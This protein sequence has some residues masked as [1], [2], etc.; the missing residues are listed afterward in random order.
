M[1]MNTSA[2]STDPLSVVLSDTDGTPTFAGGDTNNDGLLEQGETWSYTLT[3]TAPVAN[4]GDSHV[5]TATASGTDDEGN[6]ASAQ[7]TATVT[8]ANRNPAIQVVK[9]VSPGSVLEGTSGQNVTY[10]YVVT[11]TSAAST[12]PLSVVLSDSDGTPT[13]V[14]GDSNND[15]LLQQD[16]TWSYTLTVAAPVGNVGDSHVNTA[17]ATGTDDE[18][19]TA[20]AQDTATVTYTNVNP[21]IQVVKS[22]SPGSVLEGTS[23][24]NVTYSYVVTNTSAASTDPLSVVLSDS[25]GT[26]TF[27]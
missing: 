27:M 20:S 26:P 7:D 2:A 13:F 12:D 18:G 25:D 5:N 6:T 4:A 21:A 3:V 17:T 1:G 10:S 24:Q 14:G 11:N 8:Y 15:G 23:G 9:S 19:N 22:V 16:E